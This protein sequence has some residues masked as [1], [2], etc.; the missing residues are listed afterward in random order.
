M[1]YLVFYSLLHEKTS[2]T[3]FGRLQFNSTTPIDDIEDV[4][5]MELSIA[6]KR[7]WNV[8]MVVI[9][10]IIKLPL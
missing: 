5:Q 4:N 10:N 8:E 1:K 7:G 9:T 2:V 3:N 6:K